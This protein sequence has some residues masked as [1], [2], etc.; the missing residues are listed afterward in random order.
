MKIESGGELEATYAPRVATGNL[1][2]VAGVSY[3]D[4]KYKN[5]PN[6]PV[7]VQPQAAGGGTAFVACSASP[8]N[9]ALCD[10]SGRTMIKAPEYTL[11][12]RGSYSVPVGDNELGVS[13]SWFHTAKFYWDPENR[14]VQP[15]YDLINAQAYFAFG[16]DGNYR[17][18]VFGNNLADKR[19]F[20]YG[21]TSGTGDNMVGGLPR[22]YGVGVSLKY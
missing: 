20:A 15:S 5:F 13:A 1:T 21:S 17:V 12:L 8:A 18:N 10:L 7:A 4:A 6:G 11:S 22:T 9:A 19:Y 14:L 3:L 16:P 2:I